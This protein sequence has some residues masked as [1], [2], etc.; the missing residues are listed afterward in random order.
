MKLKTIS[1]M[2]V[3]IMSGCLTRNIYVDYPI[4]PPSHF[5]YQQNPPIGVGYNA[6]YQFDWWSKWGDSNL[7][8]LINTALLNNLDYKQLLSRIK[9]SRDLIRIRTTQAWPLI[10]LSA[11]SGR[12]KILLPQKSEYF[13]R[14]QGLG[15]K[16]EMDLFG[17]KKSNERSAFEKYLSLN[18]QKRASQLL[19]STEVAKTYIRLL[20]LVNKKRIVL[21]MVSWQ[22][23][24]VVFSQKL[25][26]MG[27][28]DLVSKNKVLN[29]YKKIED[30]KYEVVKAINLYTIKLAILLGKN[31]EDFSFDSD[32]FNYV[33]LD[34]LL[35]KA[36]IPRSPLP[37]DVLNKRW[38]VAVQYHLLRSAMHE[39]GA[40]HAS[41]YPQITFG[42]DINK[43]KVELFGQN[44][45]GSIYNLGFSLSFPFFSEP[46]RGMVQ[47][48]RDAV[49]R[50]EEKYKDTIIR[51]LAEIERYYIETQTS[52]KEMKLQR[53]IFS[54]AAENTT[55]LTEEYRSG[56]VNYIQL[57]QAKGEELR[58][59]SFLEDTKEQQLDT[60]TELYKSMGGYWTVEP[61]TAP[62]INGDPALRK[63]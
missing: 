53:E 58:E 9:E 50:Q 63:S 26:S 21:D 48:K 13:A 42:Y 57:A 47:A 49:K 55:K 28:L 5:K 40:A 41:L 12:Q 17:V 60:I 6:V 24:A 62:K 51:A 10:G 44:I 27:L 8:T 16:W 59:E 1:L 18:S 22:K 20:S 33:S 39:L 4:S 32:N 56:E 38:D 54:N 61:A 34:S 31:P 52:T 2:S 45:S 7:S 19:L 30:K 35:T 11:Q 46:L 23:K 37:I 15:I 3:L 25:W 36:M 43:Q 29:A 14:Q